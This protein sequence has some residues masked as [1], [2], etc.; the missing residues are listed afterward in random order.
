MAG[1]HRV[2]SRRCGKCLVVIDRSE[3]VSP[4]AP[5][6]LNVVGTEQLRDQPLSPE[7]LSALEP[8]EDMIMGNEQV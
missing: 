4:A 1:S 7:E 2:S 3:K 5:S 6:G 8:Y